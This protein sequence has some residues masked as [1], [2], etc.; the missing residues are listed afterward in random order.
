MSTRLAAFR[1]LFSKPTLVGGKNLTAYVLPRTDYHN[2]RDSSEFSDERVHWLSGFSGS[3]AFAIVTTEKALLW[4]DGRYFQQ[5]TDE[6]A[7]GWTLMKQ[8]EDGVPEPADWLV[9]NLPAGAAVGFDPHLFGFA[10]AQELTKK[11][12]TAGVEAISLLTNLVDE[13]WTDRPQPQPTPLIHLTKEEVGETPTEKFERI[14]KELKQKKC[15]SIVIS[16]LAEVAWTFNLRGA[17]IPFNPVFFAV[18]ALTLTEAH[19]FVDERKLTADVRKHLEGVRLHPYEDVIAWIQQHHEGAKQTDRQTHRVWIP[20]STNYAWGKLVA[21]EHALVAISPVRLMK[22]VKNEAELAGMRASHIRDAGVLVQFECWLKAEVAAGRAVTEKQAADKVLEFRRRVDRFVSESFATISAVGPHAALPHY[23]MTEESGRQPIERDNVFLCD[24]G[25]Q[26]RDGTTDVTRTIVIGTASA[27]VKR[28]NTLVL[29]GHILNAALT[30]PV[31]YIRLD[32]MA[33]RFL[34]QFGYD[35]SHGVGHGVGHFLNVHEGP[36]TIGYRHMDKVSKAGFRKGMIVTIEPGYY[37]VG[38]FGI[39]IESDFEL[40]EA[41]GLE[42]GA[43]NFLKFRPLTWVPIQTS[44]IERELLTKEEASPVLFHPLIHPFVQ[45]EWLNDYHKT[46]IE[47][48]GA[49][50]KKEGHN[51]AYEYLVEA[52]KPI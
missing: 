23:H 11:L 36:P 3:N 49:Y 12:K 28:M 52:C 38:A 15:D 46:C 14:R 51:E 5:A 19:L 17:D 4:T 32:S 21:E 35:F 1:S 34:W 41:T 13:L 6:L 16:D 43:S 44:L 31:G 47:T 42:S 29:K 45:I 37:E 40:V 33:R 9:E 20:D 8:R 50:L 22:A 18:G 24:S 39:R 48:T 7:D 25:A 26:Y 27:H 2:A 10:D 30:I